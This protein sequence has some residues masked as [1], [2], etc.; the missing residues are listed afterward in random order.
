MMMIG[1]T[2][3][4]IVGVLFI[5][6]M[7]LSAWEKNRSQLYEHEF[8]CML[9]EKMPTDEIWNHVEGILKKT[10]SEMWKN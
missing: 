10:G 4:I 8:R 2:V 9:I 1:M 3:L 5:E 7:L 6:Q